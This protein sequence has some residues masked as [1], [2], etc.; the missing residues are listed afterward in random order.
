MAVE[1]TSDSFLVDSTLVSCF[2]PETDYTFFVVSV[3]PAPA[4]VLSSLLATST[5]ATTTATYACNTASPI[6]QNGGFESGSLSPW[7]VQSNRGQSSGSVVAGGSNYFAGSGL[8]YT[9]GNYNYLASLNY[10][11][12][13]YAGTVSQTLIQTLNTCAGVTYDV[14]ADYKF[15][16]GSGCSISFGGGAPVNQAS[17]AS[18]WQRKAWAFTASTNS[19]ALTI[20]MSCSSN[21]GN[22]IGIDY[23]NITKA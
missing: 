17:T 20:A 6:I 8:P 10:P 12:Y 16:L 19:T 9:G 18:G 4:S 21:P 14:T 11:D 2:W 15:Q 22:A 23:V 1:R 3:V 13:P 7:V 5:V